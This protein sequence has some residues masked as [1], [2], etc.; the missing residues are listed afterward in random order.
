MNA[1][2]VN[3]QAGKIILAPMEGVVDAT[4]RHLITKLG[5]V[6]LC[7]T[8][9]IRITGYVLPEK[10]FLKSAPELARQGKTPAGIPVV[11]QL[12]G[13][14]PELLAMNAISA[15]K[16]GAPAIDLNFGCPS[17]TVNKHRGGAV[18]LDE[19]ALIH[20]I[21]KAVRQA[22]PDNIPVTAKMRL[23][24]LDKSLAIDNAVAIQEAGA[25]SLA[26]HARTKVEGYKPPAHW[27]WIGRIKESVDLHVVANGEVWNCEDY[28][29][30]KDL[31]G[32]DDVMIGR[33]LIA[34]PELGLMIKS[35]Q[36]GQS[37]DGAAWSQVV[38]LLLEY[39]SF[40]EQKLP[41]KYVHGRIKQW[42][43]MMRPQREEAE[44][45]FFSVKTINDLSDL[46]ACLE[47]EL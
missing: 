9:F 41:P 26:V 38:L 21:V 1:D 19:P 18:L 39:F 36:L 45:L 47:R 23:G 5:G 27:E 11:V 25:D 30:C 3:T 2:K 7:V 16:M 4:M 43:H 8:E 12:L 20:Q 15:A 24:N 14:E 40:V 29:R 32:C 10:E 34:R 31:S 17:K 35:Y 42:L 33:G 22:V 37:G 44:K 6:D 46:R 28:Q 13:S